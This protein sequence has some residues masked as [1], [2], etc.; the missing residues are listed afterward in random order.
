MIA[1]SQGYSETAQA[2][3]ALGADVNAENNVS[4]CTGKT[5]SFITYY[6]AMD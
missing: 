4:T 1:A 5:M 3:I 6:S 2:L